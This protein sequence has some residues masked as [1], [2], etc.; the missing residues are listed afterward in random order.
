MTHFVDELIGSPSAKHFCS[1]SGQ[2]IY[3]GLSRF[4]CD[5]AALRT[6]AL[7]TTSKNLHKILAKGLLFVLFHLN[8]SPSA[9]GIYINWSSLRLD[10]G[11]LL[12]IYIYII[13]IL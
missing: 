3:L 5:A 10:R 4:I 2:S 13:V 8:I 9:I 11:I 7:S 6:A 12:Y 1:D